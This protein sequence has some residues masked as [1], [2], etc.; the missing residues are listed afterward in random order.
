M[1]NYILKYWD[2]G[3]IFRSVRMRFK[4]KNDA[5]KWLCENDFL[6]ATVVGIKSINQ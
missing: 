1:R 2:K 5:Y 4:S 6:P 3:S